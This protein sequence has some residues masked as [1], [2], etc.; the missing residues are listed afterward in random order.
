MRIQ[1]LALALAVA[2]AAA[3]A[4]AQTNTAP[5]TAH[6][7][8]DLQGV[9]TSEYMPLP[10]ESRPDTP[11]LVVTEAQSKLLALQ[12]AKEVHA[13]KALELDPE[14]HDNLDEMAPRGLGV[15][16]GERR[17]RQVVLPANGKL[18][19]TPQARAQA[20]LVDNL[21]RLQA[22][23]PFPSNNPEDRPNAERCIVG[24]GQPPIA[25]VGAMNP[26]NI[27]QAR[28]QVVIQSEYGNDVRIVP[29]TDKHDL[30]NVG[31]VLGDSIAR[32]EGETLVVETIGMPAKD[33]IR[34]LPTIIVPATATVTERFTRVGPNELLYQYTVVD[35]TAYTAPWLAEYSL[36]R[37]RH[38]LIEF[39]C[40]EGNY[41]LTNILSGAR[42]VEQPR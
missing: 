14:I 20:T 23:P 8:P 29:L 16:K 30:R 5:R 21:L 3:P 4:E 2:L 28:D 11:T 26:R 18:P 41:S 12:F 25:N 19:Y 36:F 33:S 37:S 38:R 31:S 17:T 10:I 42:L 40:H 7:Q 15:V 34:P 1:T 27:V 13:M 6:G 22:V 24:Q 35:P 9:W 32:W 39:A